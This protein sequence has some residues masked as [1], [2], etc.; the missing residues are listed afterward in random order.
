MN[1]RN[2]LKGVNGCFFLL[3]V[4]MFSL[5]FAGCGGDKPLIQGDTLPDF[6]LQTTDHTR[7]YANRQRGH[8]MVLVFWAT[9]C[10][11]CKQELIE[12]KKLPDQFAP[13][14]VTVAGICTDPE[15]TDHIRQVVQGFNIEFPILLDEGARLFKRLGLNAYPTTV[16]VGQDGR[17]IM[18]AKGFNDAV[19][20]QMTSKITLTLEAGK[21]G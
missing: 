12:I 2:L 7:F 21:K 15:N 17:V 18:V 6:M 14:Q 19:Y 1:N 20:R 8:V 3:A 9:W 4:I 5:V 10:N 13:G 16:A 11:H